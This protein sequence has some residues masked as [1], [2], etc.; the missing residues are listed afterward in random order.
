MKEEISNEFTYTS[1]SHLDRKQEVPLEI[2][3]LPKS[4]GDTKI[5]LLPRDPW[6]CFTYW[7]ISEKTIQE[8]KSLY[9]E[10]FKLSIRVYDVTNV[11][12]FDGRNANKFFDIDIDNLQI[13]SWYINLPEVNRSWCV[14]L[15][16][17]T[18]DG[19]FIV[20]SRSN[21]VMMPRFG[22]STLSDE[23]WAILQKEFER[24]LEMSGVNRI[25][26]GSFDIAKLMRE[27][28]EE[29]MLISQMPQ[30]ISSGFVSSFAKKE[31]QLGLKEF[32][33]KADT[34]LIIYGE[35]MPDAKLYINEEEY[36]LSKDGRFS[37][38]IHLTDGKKVFPI[39]AISSDGSM[40]KQITF[41]VTRET[42]NK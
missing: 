42:E 4:Y 29:L 17:K 40:Q 25:G 33:L 24:L 38:R 31:E 15:G 5:V 20:L 23:Q 39:K 30:F 35:T 37:L 13:S 2:T 3:D 19:R 36:K 16:I 11:N 10:N 34:E 7:E 9:G 26:I 32:F 27:R 18:Q 12:N 21:I 8:V 22:V 1:S 6:W 28:W 14:D 41:V